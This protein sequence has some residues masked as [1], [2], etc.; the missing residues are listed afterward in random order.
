MAKRE[1]MHKNE[2]P[3]LQSVWRAALGKP[4][5]IRLECKDAAEAKRLRF[6]LYN[7][8]RHVR[9]DDGARF[10]DSQLL[11]AVDNCSISFIEE[12]VLLVRDNKFSPLRLVV[13]KALE[14]YGVEVKGATDDAAAASAQRLNAKLAAAGL[15]SPDGEVNEAMERAR[16]KANEYYGKQ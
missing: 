11:E 2:D 13:A 4:D 7:A 10:A 8:V 6:A 5:G 12:R 16:Q 15:A 1:R 9:T 14:E 3:E